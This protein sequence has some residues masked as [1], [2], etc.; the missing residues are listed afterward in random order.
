MATNAEVP[1]V[2]SRILDLPWHAAVLNIHRIEEEEMPSASRQGELGLSA[3]RGKNGPK[4]A[5]RRLMGVQTLSKF[6]IA[7]AD[8]QTAATNEAQTMEPSSPADYVS[9]EEDI[10]T[11][12]EMEM[13]ER[14]RSELIDEGHFLQNAWLRSTGEEVSVAPNR[15]LVVFLS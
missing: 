4:I 11:E 10:F 2:L 6:G 15:P 3:R 7:T 12:Y 5:A 8:T 13:L 1:K 14:T 9:L